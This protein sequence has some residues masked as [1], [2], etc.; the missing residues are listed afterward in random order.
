MASE[1]T[2]NHTYRT[3][4]SF[5]LKKSS[6]TCPLHKRSYKRNTSYLENTYAKHQ[7]AVDQFE[8]KTNKEQTSPEVPEYSTGLTQATKFRTKV[9]YLISSFHVHRH[10]END[11]SSV[12]YPKNHTDTKESLK[13]LV[14][15]RI[16]LKVTFQKYIGPDS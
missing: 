10:T 14:K 8:S 13:N 11:P 1:M 4:S 7:K 9:I 5:C 16:K 2:K 12:S 3:P 15:T 6:I